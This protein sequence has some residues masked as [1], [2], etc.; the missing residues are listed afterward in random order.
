MPLASEE[1]GAVESEGAD[2]D[3]DL[4]GFGGGDGALFEFKRFWTSRFVDYRC[5]HCRH[6]GANRSFRSGGKVFEHGIEI[7]DFEIEVR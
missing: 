1:F 4:A 7:G 3:E 5:F 2:A 6:D